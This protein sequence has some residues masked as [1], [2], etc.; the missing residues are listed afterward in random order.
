[1]SKLIYRFEGGNMLA[2]V[3]SNARIFDSKED[4]IKFLIEES[5]IICPFREENFTFERYGSDERVGW[6]KVYMVCYKGFYSGMMCYEEDIDFSKPWDAENWKGVNPY[7]DN[8]PKKNL[9][10]T[11]M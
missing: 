3:M 7:S 2:E 5:G 8:Y 11:R 9:K 6:K 4:L 1:M 10:K